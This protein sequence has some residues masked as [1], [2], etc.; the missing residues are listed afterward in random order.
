MTNKTDKCGRDKVERK[1]L[2]DQMPSSTISSIF[3]ARKDYMI[4]ALTGKVGSGCS[5]VSD[6]L[7]NTRES[8]I[9]SRE[10]PGMAGFQSDEERA[11]SILLRYYREN[12]PSFILIRVRDVITSFLLEDGAWKRLE[13]YDKT[14]ADRKPDGDG[15]SIL[16]RVFNEAVKDEIVK[17]GQAFIAE[18]K[19]TAGSSALE[20]SER[21]LESIEDCKDYTGCFD[22]L[23]KYCKAIFQ[24]KGSSEE[25]EDD[26]EK[27]K[28]AASLFIRVILP[29][30]ATSIRMTL[31]K[32]YT[33]AFQDFGNEL[34]FYGSL[35]GNHEQFWDEMQKNSNFV[36][37]PENL[38]SDKDKTMFTIAKRI[39][40]MIKWIKKPYGEKR[41][42]AI[43]IDS[44]KNKYE[45]NFLRDRYSA[46]YLLAV[47]R[48]EDK[49]IQQLLSDERKNFS[50][51][52]ID[53]IDY[54]ERPGQAAKS[55]VKFARCMLQALASGKRGQIPS[56]VG[57]NDFEYLKEYLQ[58]IGDQDLESLFGYC[59]GEEKEKLIEILGKGSV[60]HVLR[61][62]WGGADNILQGTFKSAE[63]TLSLCKYC[64]TI[65]KDPLR[66]FLYINK[67]FP[68]Y[69]QDVEACIQ[70]AD[71]FLTNN[72]PDDGPKHDLKISLFR[73]ISLMIHPGLLT[74]TPVER[75][76]Q[77][78]YTAKANSGCISR[79]V[80]A[81]VTDK[82]YNILSLGW[83][84]VP[85]GQTPC[86]YRNLLDLRSQN[87]MLA[88]SDYEWS[89]DS[90]FHKYI[91]RFDF[92]D[93]D[94][95]AR[96]LPGLSGSFCFKSL[97]E[98]VM[99]EKNP[100]NARA[101]H[102][103]EKALLQC[104]KER[105]VGGYLFT[106]S[107]PCEMCAKNAKEHR[108]STIYY[109]EPYPGISQSHVCN[110][111]REDNRAQYVLFEGAIGRAYTQLYTPVLPYKDELSLRGF[112]NAFFSG[113]G[114]SGN[115]SPS[116]AESKNSQMEED[117]N[118]PRGRDNGF[119]QKPVRTRGPAA[120]WKR[121][122]KK[123]GNKSHRRWRKREK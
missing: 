52:D 11:N 7:H 87:D 119:S 40:A 41:P 66:I 44:M 42:T 74:P 113:T 20:Q 32:Q 115:S 90:A 76:M 86:L 103:E 97:N 33:F 109:I 35:A 47:S 55:I 43:V 57:K 75:C 14:P 116:P 15:E 3:S 96:I 80:G 84:D 70:N 92:Q 27:L 18:E 67:L 30:I 78:A 1:A 6:F 112:P 120:R 54:N 38:N 21:L 39:N 19:K 72:E 53:V 68:F 34:R 36:F 5:L 71:I 107:S 118:P 49:R 114:G 98:E 110:S 62:Q 73:Y 26:K 23:Q 65:L 79:Q 10:S 63:L 85:C 102:G 88:Y 104:N 29:E 13:Q 77:I 122:T 100:M 89:Q 12:L 60:D 69:L 24:E 99:S 106:T 56:G 111:G 9:L 17:K 37:Q 64:Q 117:L 61:E 59:I 93:E 45:S 82:D 50:R 25:V 48:E 108:I 8:F 58:A 121:I 94:K 81:V 91:N 51:D 2:I 46:Y 28:E 101:M 22:T 123:K 83:N 16:C 4:V 31:G 95:V 105:A